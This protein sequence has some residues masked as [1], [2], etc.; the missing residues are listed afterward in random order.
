MSID[1]FTRTSLKLPKHL[2]LHSHQLPIFYL[3][4]FPQYHILTKTHLLPHHLLPI[5]L[6]PMHL[7]LQINQSM[8]HLT[9]ITQTLHASY[10]YTPQTANT[11]ISPSSPTPSP[12]ANIHPMQTHKKSRGV[13]GFW[14]VCGTSLIKAMTTSLIF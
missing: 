8:T 6:P 2:H 14:L 9:F 4:I 10:P 12:P 1:F 7:S 3:P 11:T 13:H 5:P